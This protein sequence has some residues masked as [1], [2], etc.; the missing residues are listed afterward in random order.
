M[1]NVQPQ[2]EEVLYAVD[3]IVR[4][5][6]Q[7][8]AEL[9]RKAAGNARNRIR[10]C[11]HRNIEDRLHEMLI[12]HTRDTY[13]RPH[14]HLGRS[15]SFHVIEGEVDV[16]IFDEAGAVADVLRLGSYSSGK[17]FYYRIA[18]PLYHTLLI[19]SDVIVFHESINGPFCREDMVFAPWEPEATDVAAQKEFLE[20]VERDVAAFSS[21]KP[22]SCQELSRR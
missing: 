12:V 11:T 17:T 21:G 5:N 2:N 1:I 7:D 9:I 15:E 3:P 6:R 22:E 14:K 18:D 13:V 20:R 16:V 8:I 19:R 4:V 10:V